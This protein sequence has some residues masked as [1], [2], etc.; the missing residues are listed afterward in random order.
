MNHGIIIHPEDFDD[1]LAMSN[2]ECGQIVKNLLNTL[3]G[4]EITEFEDRYLVRVSKD[5]CGRV[6]RDKE[7]SERQ[8]RKGKL[9]GGQFG[10]SNATKNEPKRAEN[11]PKTSRKRTETNP[12]TNTNTNTNNKRL[13]GECENVKLTEDEYTK[14]ID[15]GYSGLIDELSLYIASKGDKYKDHYATVL[16][17]ARK[18]EKERPISK[19][20]FTRMTNRTDYDM[21]EL[22]RV[23]V[24]N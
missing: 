11:E 21:D 17:W 16:S 2:E 18:R 5:M 23:L 8:S 22:E 14:L 13:Y 12:N 15:K 24:K 19:N 10:N 6:L 7:L 1:L 3:L 4:K 20:T 9:G